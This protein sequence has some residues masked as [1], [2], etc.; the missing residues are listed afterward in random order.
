VIDKKS[1]FSNGSIPGVKEHKRCI[2]KAISEELE[3][4]KESPFHVPISKALKGGKRI[5]PIILSLSHE[6]VGEEGNPYPAAAAVEFAHTE[7]LIHDDLIDED[8]TRRD[9][10]SFHIRYDKETTIL[11]ADFILSVI[12]KIASYYSDP[13]IL[14]S[15]SRAASTMCEGELMEIRKYRRG[16]NFDL[17]EYLDT[18]TKKTAILFEVSA[19]IGGLIGNAQKDELKAL[20]KYGKQFGKSYQIKDDLYDFQKKTENN[21]LKNLKNSS[22]FRDVL[23]EESE[24]YIAKAKKNLKELNPSNARQLLIDIADSTEP[25]IDNDQ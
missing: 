1:A 11:S 12:L 21:I 14:R 18:I 5:R 16:S 15:L 7:S 19:K 9:E 25:H 22:D 2:E 13:R 20:S 6:S 23:K 10:E 8:R 24:K 4:F 3:K 17:N